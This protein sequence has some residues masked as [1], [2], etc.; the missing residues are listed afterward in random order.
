MT[1]PHDSIRIVVR[2][3]PAP[4][5][6]K[7]LLGHG[8]MVESSKKVKPWREAVRSAA[9]DARLVELDLSMLPP[10]D[11]PLVASMVFT[12][13]KPQSAPK[14]RRTWPDRTPDLSKLVRSTEDALTDAGMWTDDARVVEYVRLAK[15]FPGE[16]PEA[17]EV[18][19]V[20]IIVQT[21][22][23]H[24]LAGGLRHSPV[25]VH[26]SYAALAAE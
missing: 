18:P 1:A 23:S 2:G 9:E 7:R 11:G 26:P 6:S 22:A 14:R 8:A 10:L 12:L 20:V 15:V 17:L 21:M 16:D 3:T 19:G 25:L 5:G 13:R 4:Q 24:E